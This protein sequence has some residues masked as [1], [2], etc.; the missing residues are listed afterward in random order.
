[1][2][3][4]H[5]LFTVFLGNRVKNRLTVL[6]PEEG[7]ELRDYGLNPD[8]SGMFRWSA[9]EVIPS[10]VQYVHQKDEHLHKKILKVLGLREIPW[11][12]A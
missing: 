3:P 6:L 5:G 4:E 9:D 10:S 7:K 11:K 8:G 2:D 1:M 12:D